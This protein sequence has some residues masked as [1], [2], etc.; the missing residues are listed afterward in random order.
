MN[1]I[2][3]PGSRPAVSS[4]ALFATATL[5]L[6]V[7]ALL[8][9]GYA[10]IAFSIAT[11]FL[12][13]GPHNWIEA[14]YFLARLPGRFGKLKGFFL[15]AFAGV[16]LLSGAYAA[17]PYF[18]ARGGLSGRVQF[19]AVAMWDTLL[20]GWIAVLVHLRS[21]QNPRRD[22]GWLL[23]VALAAAALAWIEPFAW[24]LVL[25]YAHPLMALWILDRELRRSMPAWRRPYHACLA[26]LPLALGILWWHLALAAPLGGDDDLTIRIAQHAGA[27]FLPALSSH[28]LVSTH[29]FLEMLHYSVWLIAIPLI[30]LRSAPWQLHTIALGRRSASWRSALAAFLALG[31]LAVFILWACFLVNYSIT[32]EIYFTVAILHV[33]AEAPFLLR[34]L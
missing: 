24:S 22:W 18:V 10:P 15:F 13:A 19:G 27:A 14:R 26:V 8:L 9:A 33:L 4:P 7:L 20:V 28:F 11:V 17:M 3:L 12:F 32:R 31:A 2:A 30:G 23:P 21:K 25:V 6:M 5:V 34:A 16:F 1:A 29:T